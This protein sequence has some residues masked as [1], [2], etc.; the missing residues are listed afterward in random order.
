M[1]YSTAGQRFIVT[2]TLR[3]TG[4]APINITYHAAKYKRHQIDVPAGT[5]VCQQVDKSTSAR[6]I[7]W[8][9]YSTVEGVTIDW[10]SDTTPDA[11]SV[12]LGIERELRPFFACDGFETTGGNTELHAILVNG[13]AYDAKVDLVYLTGL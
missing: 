2:F 6:Y 5:T 3:R 12:T 9:A 11:T 10:T 7:A 8:F 13:T 1:A 4:E